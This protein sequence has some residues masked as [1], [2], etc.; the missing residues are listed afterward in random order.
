[1]IHSYTDK[2]IHIRLLFDFHLENINQDDNLH[3]PKGK[4]LWHISWN[5]HTYIHTRRI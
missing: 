5:I 2:N 3:S 1:M 4:K